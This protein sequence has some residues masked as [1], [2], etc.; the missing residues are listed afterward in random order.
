MRIQGN[1]LQGLLN[2]SSTIFSNVSVLVYLLYKVPIEHTFE[3]SCALQG[4]LNTYSTIFNLN[5]QALHEIKTQENFF[6]YLRLVSEQSR[7]LQ[8]RFLKSTLCC[9]FT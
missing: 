4:L 5:E 7:L 1:A 3:N 8:A 2:T 6:D 9:A